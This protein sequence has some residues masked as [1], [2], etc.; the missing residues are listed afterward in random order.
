FGGDREAALSILPTSVHDPSWRVERAIIRGMRGWRQPVPTPLPPGRG[1]GV[2]GGYSRE[3]SPEA[4]FD[5]ALWQDHP[6]CPLPGGGRKRAVP[7]GFDPHERYGSRKATVRFTASSWADH[8][9]HLAPLQAREGLDLAVLA[10][11]FLDLLGQV[12]AEVLVRH[13]A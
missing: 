6:F 10:D 7:G 1:S 8:H 13:L 9:D 12:L 3:R 11:V 5:A 2:S 4:G